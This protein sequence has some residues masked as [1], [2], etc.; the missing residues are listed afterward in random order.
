MLERLAA[1]AAVLFFALALASEPS[2]LVVGVAAALLVAVLATRVVGEREL[3]VG[4]RAHAHREAM[5]TLP[6]PAHPSTAGRP[7]TR[8]PSMVVPAS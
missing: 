1:L 8:A 7:R 6:A 2:M 3:T 4:A 5:S